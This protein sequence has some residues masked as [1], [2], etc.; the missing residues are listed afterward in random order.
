ME[1]DTN[2]GDKAP[3][4]GTQAVARAL[5]ILEAIAERPMSLS[6]LADRVSISAPTCYRIAKAM[7]DR[8][9][10]STSG[11]SGFTLG[12]KAAELGTAYLRQ[13]LIR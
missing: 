11:R 6:D 9:L 3:R 7:A 13:Q 8:G 10:L 2:P 4:S 1:D 5:D 12:P